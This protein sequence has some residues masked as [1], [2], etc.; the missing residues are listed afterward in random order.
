MAITPICSDKNLNND[1]NI[2]EE[3]PIMSGKSQEI[4]TTV[5]GF[6]HFKKSLLLFYKF[7]LK[8]LIKAFPPT[9]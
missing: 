3:M 7:T 8:P 4:K 9:N 5:S 1:M 2:S 6:V